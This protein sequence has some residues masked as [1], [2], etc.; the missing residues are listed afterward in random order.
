VV[1]VFAAFLVT[2]SPYAYTSKRVHGSWFY[3]VNSTYHMWLDSWEE[4]MA[5]GAHGDRVQWSE[6]APED[7][8]GPFRYLREHSAATI[9][10]RIGRGLLDVIV[11]TLPYHV[12]ALPYLA[13]CLLVGSRW[14]A[15]FHHVLV[16][17]GR[18]AVTGFVASCGAAY[19]LLLAFYAPITTEARL[20][21]SQYLPPMVTAHPAVI[22]N[23]YTGK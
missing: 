3:N 9:A 19:L 10:H 4:A 17:D 6:M 16:G 15:A 20:A 22:M 18:W 8:P 23:L 7:L 5:I 14:P 2:V 12:F 21:L 1:L 13:L 11:R